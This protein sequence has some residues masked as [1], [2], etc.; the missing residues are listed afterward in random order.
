MCRG[1]ILDKTTKRT[2]KINT[3]LL[4]KNIAKKW[5]LL[6]KI[7]FDRYPDTLPMMVLTRSWYSYFS[8]ISTT[9]YPTHHINTI[10]S[11]AG[12]ST[13]SFLPFNLQNLFQPFCC[14]TFTVKFKLRRSYTRKILRKI[15]AWMNQIKSKSIHCIH[16]LIHSRTSHPLTLLRFLCKP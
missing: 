6:I 8:C 15:L 11:D 10:Y 14:I 4:Q 13:L 2:L 3:K 16:N 7:R 1:I 5:L 12:D 9:F